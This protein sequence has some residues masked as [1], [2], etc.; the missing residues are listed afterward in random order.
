[1]RPA[2][3]QRHRPIPRMRRLNR[4]PR[5]PVGQLGDTERVGGALDECRAAFAR[6]VR[7]HVARF[8]HQRTQND[9]HPWLDDARLFEGDR[10]EG[11]SEMLLMIEVNRGDG[12]RYWRDDI[13]RVESTA[14]PHLYHTDLDVGAPEQLE[15][16]R[17]SGLEERRL[18]RQHAGRA[19]PVST[20]QHMVHDGFE[21]GG[22]DGTI[23]DDEAFVQ[24]GEVR[25]G[26]SPGVDTVRA[27]RGVHH[28]GYRTLA[29]GSRDVQ[30]GEAAFGMTERF[31]QARDVV[32]PQLDAEGL[33][34]KQT[35]EQLRGQ[36]TDQDSGVDVANTGTCS[37]TDDPARSARM[38][39]RARAM[40]ALRSRRSTT[41]S[42]MPCSTRNSLRWNPSG[43]F[44]RMVC[45]MTRG[46]A[47]P[48]NALGSAMFR[49]PSIAKLAVTPPVVGSVNTDM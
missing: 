48:I 21:R 17:S 29:V 16:R 32:E 43:S 3:P 34:R 11:M 46:P 8:A 31:T 20:G 38:K 18:H 47:K 7:N 41:M 9:G 12:A 35:V 27:Q 19:Q 1:M 5:P 26:V 30:G 39:R 37:N 25:R 10:L 36:R 22:I 28:R 40:V 4:H 49:S 33:E 15:R 45:S 14:E 23:V 6:H 24:I 2:K 13:R 44:W 42:S